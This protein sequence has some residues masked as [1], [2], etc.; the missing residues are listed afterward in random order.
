MKYKIKFLQ[1]AL[2]DLDEIVLYIASD[3]KDAAIKMHDEI[4]NKSENLLKF[5]KLGRL[6]PEKKMRKKGYRML[7]IKD[8][9]M[10]YRIIDTD[11]YVY[12]VL[13]GSRN[14]PILFNKY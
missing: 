14:Y 10:F 1:S 4:I 6:I 2:D 8:Y 11:I 5:P 12:R 9:I 3:N 7:L 13:H